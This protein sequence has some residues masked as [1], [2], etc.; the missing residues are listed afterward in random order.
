MRK[1]F[2]LALEIFNLLNKHLTIGNIYCSEAFYSMDNTLSPLVSKY[3]CLGVEMESFALFHIAKQ[4]NKNAACLMTVVDSVF[5][6][7]HASSEERETNLN[8]MIKLAL[9]SI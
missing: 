5:H 7:C 4:L 3:Q 2:L 8:K 1:R 6:D 9:D